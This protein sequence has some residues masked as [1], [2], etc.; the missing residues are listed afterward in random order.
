M[1]DQENPNPV[2]PRPTI[3]TSA[4]PLKKETVR[5]TLRPQAP[6]AGEAEASA[7]AP[8]APA[9]PPRPTMAPPPRPGAPTV[10][11]TAPPRPTVPGAPP[12]PTAGGPPA[13]PRPA[14]PTVP[15]GSKTIPLSQPPAR[16][17]TPM[18]A[19]QTTKIVGGS[20]ATQALPKA[21]VKLTPGAAPTTPA[22][23]VSSVSIKTTQFE[24]EEEVN[25]GPLNIMGWVSL[26]ASIAAVI[27][28]L[29]CMD[30]ISFFS[31][32]ISSNKEAWMKNTPPQGIKLP[33]DYSPFDK[34]DLNGG[35]TS[36]YARLEPKIPARPEAP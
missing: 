24:E 6:G 13:P 4:V 1:S 10:P 20:P 16:P 31:E 22:A 23:P 35:I 2:P 12:P 30:K 11:L 3:K 26:V 28:V 8:A 32:G 29:A 19:K 14:P 27:G 15:V 36:E 5:I 34:K 7:E 18:V 25:E 21:T 33:M 9:P 17:T